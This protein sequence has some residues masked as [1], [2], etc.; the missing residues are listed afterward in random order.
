MWTTKTNKYTLTDLKTD[1]HTHT[2][3]HTQA[4]ATARP[5]RQTNTH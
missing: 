5:L 1:T 2:H 3:T 4:T